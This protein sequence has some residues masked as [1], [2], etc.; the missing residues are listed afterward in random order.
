MK[1]GFDIG[2]LRKAQKVRDPFDKFVCA[3]IVFNYHYAETRY[4]GDGG[5]RSAAVSYGV[6]MCKECEFDP[7]GIPVGE[8]LSRPIKRMDP[9]CPGRSVEVAKGNVGSLFDAIYQ[10][11]CNFFHGNKSFHNARDTALVEQGANVLI[12]LMEKIVGIQDN[13]EP[14]NI[15]GEA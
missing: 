8:Y 5:E 11:R 14:A 3:Y 1:C 9:L 12:A 7:F 10:V 6:N 2:W 15:C 13:I 4:R